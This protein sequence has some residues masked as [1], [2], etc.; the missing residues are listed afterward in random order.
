LCAT[1]AVIPAVTEGRYHDPGQRG[2]MPLGPEKI[3]LLRE[4][5]AGGAVDVALHG[6][7]HRTISGSPETHSEFVGLP[8]DEQLDK[9]RRGRESLKR[10][11]GVTTTVFVPPW[12]RYDRN[13]IA[14]LTE[15]GFTAISAN[16]Y[17]PGYE[18]VLKFVPITADM[19]ELRQAI[20][21]ARNSG[22]PDPIVGVLLHPYDFKESGDA[23]GRIEWPALDKELNWLATQPGIKVRSISELAATNTA[24]GPPRYRANQP[25][26]LESITPSFVRTT[27]ATPFL[28]SEGN[29]RQARIMRALLSGLT[30]V[31]AAVLGFAAARL[32]L[33][34]LPWPGVPA[35]GTWVAAIFLLGLMAR[36][37]SRRELHFRSMLGMSVLAGI[38]ISGG[39]LP[40]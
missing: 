19:A 10:A 23:R 11:A 36:A 5:I 26:R 40:Q 9:L 27:E 4:A 14:A 22:D 18:G 34:Q 13:T 35:A 20:A 12:N 24:L 33:P 31:V 6:W 2:V 37:A 28:R 30:Y 17:G 38:I 15:L 8:F 29:A 7:D 25:W 16:R 3:A 32:V 39:W 21:F 1:F